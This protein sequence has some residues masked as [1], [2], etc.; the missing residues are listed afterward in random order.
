MGLQVVGSLCQFDAAA[1][2]PAACVDLGFDHDEIRAGLFPQPA[3]G[4]RRF[5]HRSG[6][7]AFLDA[8]S[9]FFE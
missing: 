3:V 8:D 2:S 5:F 4:V 6:Y 1:F 7:D 9:E